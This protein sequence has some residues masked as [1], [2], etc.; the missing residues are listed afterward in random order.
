MF[1]IVWLISILL[2]ATL[3][4]LL[5]QSKIEKLFFKGEYSEAIRYF[6]KQLGEDNV[7]LTDFILVAKCFEVQFDYLSAIECYKQAL[8]LDSLNNQSL[9]G[10]ADAYVQLGIK[11]DAL[12][13]YSGLFLADSTNLR[14]SGKY[15]A[16]LSDA[17][18]HNR[19]EQIYCNL[20]SLDSTNRYFHRKLIAS[21]YK[22]EHYNR[23]VP[24]AQKYN[25]SYPFDIDMWLALITSYQQIDSV[26]VAIEELNKLLAVDSLNQ[27][28]VS[29]LAFLYF[30]KLKDY[31][32][33][34]VYYRQ[35]NRMGNNSNPF[36]LMN[37]G[38]SAFFVGEYEHAAQLLDSLTTVL[39]TDPM[40]PFYAGL[41]YKQLGEN[42]LALDFIEQAA[43]LAIPAYVSD[44]F[45]HL[46]RAYSTLRMFPKAL[47]A[48]EKSLEIDPEKFLVYYDLAITHEEYNL[49]RKEALKNYQLFLEKCAN[50]TTV[51]ANYAQSRIVK[52]KE[53]LFFNGN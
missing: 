47:K 15:A 9:E 1:K 44:I 28:A 36:F 26:F 13:I 33:A 53:E 29:K 4:N 25:E 22:Q 50:K 7:D 2:S 12:E 20:Y 8:Q 43:F 6:E 41:S 18:V 49:N 16:L 37:Q 3:T 14:I 10:L 35:L 17:G 52:I 34:Y 32:L 39:P 38:I 5:A 23:V 21:I 31:E 30:S 48:F 40:L 42:Q 46:G 24:I 27:I 19:A 51:E 11:K 45:Q